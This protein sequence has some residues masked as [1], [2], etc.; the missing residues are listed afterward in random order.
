MTSVFCAMLRVARFGKQGRCAHTCYFCVA[1]GPQKCLLGSSP[2]PLHLW[3][4]RH[5][6]HII[7]KRQKPLSHSFRCSSSPHKASALRGPLNQK[8]LLSAAPALPLLGLIFPLISSVAYNK[9]ERPSCESTA[10]TMASAYSFSF[11]PSAR[12]G[13]AAASSITSVISCF[14]SLAF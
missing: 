6:L 8:S 14:N 2:N 12:S 10:R 13:S 7:R 9:K 4:R 1:G 3:T 5:K 11:S